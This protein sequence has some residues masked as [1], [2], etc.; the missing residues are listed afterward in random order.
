M[1]SNMARGRSLDELIQNYPQYLKGP[2]DNIAQVPASFLTIPEHEDLSI[3]EEEFDHFGDAIRQFWVDFPECLSLV[4]HS[5]TKRPLI[6][7]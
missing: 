4:A 5:E 7:I 1:Y 3:T 2:F 6:P